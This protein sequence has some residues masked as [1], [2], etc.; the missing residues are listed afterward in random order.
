M[1]A[2]APA[3]SAQ[4][5]PF[6]IQ[7]FMPQD[8]DIFGP[9][10]G[11]APNCSPDALSDK[12]DG[13]DSLA[14]L[15]AVATPET[16]QVTWYACPL[17]TAVT[18]QAALS[19]CNVVIGTDS[20][21][22]VPPIGP[23]A[24]SP[25]DEA[26]DVNWDIPGSLDQQRRDIAALAC[27][28][29][30]Q[31]VEGG[32]ANCR[33]DEENNIF[34][35]D[36]QTGAAANQTSSGEFGQYRTLQG[37]L[38]VAP[39]NAACDAAR[40]PFPHGS[41]VPN[42]GFDVQAFTSDDVNALG[43]IVNSPADASTEP[44]PAN[45]LNGPLCSLEQTF[46][47]FKRWRCFFNDAAIP[48]DAEMAISLDDN[49]AVGAKPEGTGGYC[50]SNNNPASTPS[51]QNEVPGAHD[52]CILDSHY[53]VSSAR[54][55]SRFV[56][57][58]APNPPSPSA[59]ASCAAPDTDETSNL[60]T[61]EDA[62]LCLFDQFSDPFA[63]PW[64]ETTSGAGSIADCGPEG[65]GH[66]HNGDGRFEDCVGNTGADGVS[67]GLTFQNPT[68]PTGDQVLTGCY[69]PQNQTTVPPVANHGCAD[70]GSTLTA[71]KTIHWGT[72]ASEVFLAYNNPAPT[73]PSDPCR[74]GVTFKANDVG[75]FDDITVCT[76]DSSGNP[77]PTNPGAQRLQW[78]ITGAQGEEPT[79]IRF[80]PAPPPDETSGSGAS[81]S[82]RIEAVQEGDN[83]VNVF[84][85]DSNGDVVDAFSLE[86]Q[87]HGENQPRDVTTNLTARK[88]KIRI[89]GKAN[90]ESEC[91]PGRSVT[92][93]KRRRGPDNVIGTD[94]TNSLGRWSVPAR[95]RGTYYAR[96]AGS[97][98][99]DNQGGGV[100]NC[101]P[102][103][104]NDVRRRRRG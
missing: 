10:C 8:Q 15:T 46:T 47:N 41:P 57:T 23:G 32:S 99:T 36:A 53:A 37:C 6:G 38:D 68:G 102:D 65:T 11:G 21:G 80:N 89:R 28:G 27:I 96:I 13:V 35:E 86:K 70:A 34:L 94:D 54:Q 66:D 87:V 48:N 43:A 40:K 88:S 76:F 4:G 101:L 2:I 104:S 29:T 63:G 14:H 30:A 100:L 52:F 82:A 67:T 3:A 69:D 58:F 49:T 72:Q 92:L 61:T 1:L 9:G 19:S 93:F 95:G 5:R 25:A 20:T 62:T 50:N 79:A 77:V 7:Q 91:Q 81:A 84:L 55:A 64:T 75:D 51:A 44:A 33:V 59:N 83:F 97:T 45:Q 78:T 12:F 24:S 42:D 39:G 90:T 73:N 18:T 22:V 85:L 16:T 71:T 17:G 98:A 74:T 103:Q 31:Q 26:Y 60:G 56:Q